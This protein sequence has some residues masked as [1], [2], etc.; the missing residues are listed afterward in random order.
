ML[1]S[2]PIAPGPL[3]WEG[4]EW[5][6]VTCLTL[7]LM[8]VFIVFAASSP[9]KAGPAPFFWEGVAKCDLPCARTYA[10]FPCVCYSPACARRVALLFSG[11]RLLD[12]AYLAQGGSRFFSGGRVTYTFEAPGLRFGGT[13]P[14]MGSGVTCLAQ[15]GSHFGCILGQCFGHVGLR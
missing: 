8:H 15:G 9:C 1:N 14:R 10:C 2:L 6:G 4:K 13:R 3:I 7:G 12:A 5:L 11:R